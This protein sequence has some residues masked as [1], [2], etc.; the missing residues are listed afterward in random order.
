M[1][2]AL[3]AHRVKHQGFT[4]VFPAKLRDGATA[5]DAANHGYSQPSALQKPLK[6][7]CAR[8]KIKKPVS[9][10]W[11]RHTWNNLLR[12]TADRETQQALVGH[13]TEEMSIH[14]SHVSLGEKRAAVAR[15]LALVG[16]KG[17]DGSG[18]R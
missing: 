9:P 8:A 6:A 12:Q 13:S 16:P 17:G 18:D 11:L 3:R 1:A 2:E 7:A 15:V 10:H 5:T 4:L 14:Y